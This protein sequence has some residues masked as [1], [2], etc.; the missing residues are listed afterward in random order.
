MSDVTS[1]E[2]NLLRVVERYGGLVVTAAGVARGLGT[3]RQE[4]A[5]MAVILEAAGM[6]SVSRLPKQVTYS[7]TEAGSRELAENQ[8]TYLLVQVNDR[9][10][11]DVAAYLLGVNGVQEVSVHN[12]EHP[13]GCCCQNCPHNGNCR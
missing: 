3:S 7:L 9:L 13:N 2:R 5:A 8:F 4:V 10:A 12:E 6:L 11:E 1:A